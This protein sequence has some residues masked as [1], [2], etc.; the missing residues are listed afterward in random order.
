MPVRK[1]VAVVGPTNSGKTALAQ[2]IAE[3]FSGVIISSDSRQIYRELKIGANKEGLSGY[4]QKQPCRYLGEIPQLL[5]DIAHY[6]ER[7]S[8][9]DWLEVARD[10]LEKI[11]QLNRLPIIVGGTGLYVTALLENYQLI[12]Q[13]QAK[14]RELESKS[15]AQLQELVGANSGLNQ[16]DYAN[17]RRLI[18]FLKRGQGRS[19]QLSQF[20][21]MII[22][23]AVERSELYQRSDHWV[24]Q[25]FDL[26]IDEVKVLLEQGI[27]AQWLSQ[28]GFV[29][30]LASQVATGQTEFSNGQEKLKVVLRQF[31]RRQQ[32]WWRHHGQVNLV[33]DETEAEQLIETFLDQ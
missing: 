17:P 20:R 5:V 11:W 22:A 16:S 29:Y 24:N 9:N 6:P 33:K 23:L 14:T 18:G 2:K 30:D 15:L 31:I 8:L 28:L 27:S 7:F 19:I 32:T 13:D 10:N 4:W 21:S 25:R 12:G 26:I 3:R 1:V